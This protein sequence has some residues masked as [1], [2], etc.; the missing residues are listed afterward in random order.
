[1]KEDFLVAFCR[2]WVDCFVLCFLHGLGLLRDV[3][4]LTPREID[5]KSCLLSVFPCMVGEWGWMVGWCQRW[6]FSRRITLLHPIAHMTQP[7]PA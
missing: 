6:I 5:E 1:M 7:T 4:G 3:F 2:R